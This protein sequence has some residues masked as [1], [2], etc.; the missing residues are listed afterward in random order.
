MSDAEGYAARSLHLTLWC[1]FAVSFWAS[2]VA[3]C[4]AQDQ[5]SYCY[6]REGEKRKTERIILD[7]DEGG[8]GPGLETELFLD[9]GLIMTLASLMAANAKR[10]TVRRDPS[11]P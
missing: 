1:Y 11:C 3:T 10:T 8:V 9:H 4:T 2:P 7:E 5:R 6:H